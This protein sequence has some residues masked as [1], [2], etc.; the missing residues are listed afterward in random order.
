MVVVGKA[1]EGAGD[2]DDLVDVAAD[3]DADLSNGDAGRP[4][5]TS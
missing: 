1:V 3:G 4:N 5:E 2:R